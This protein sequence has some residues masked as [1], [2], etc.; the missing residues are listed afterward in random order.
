MRERMGL[1]TWWWL[2]DCN[3]VQ[4]DGNGKGGAWIQGDQGEI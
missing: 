2:P 3:K 4:L 1:I